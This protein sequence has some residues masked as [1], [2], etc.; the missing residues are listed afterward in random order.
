MTRSALAPVALLL[1]LFFDSAL[2]ADGIPVVDRTG[3]SAAPVVSGSTVVIPSNVAT[4]SRTATHANPVK[5]PAAV[6]TAVGELLMMLDQLQEEVAMLRGQVEQQQHQLRRMQT[7]Q[8]DRYRDLDR[9]LSLL[10]QKVLAAPPTSELLL[11]ASLPAASVETIPAVAA[12][13][14]AVAT[15]TVSDAQAFK[16]SFAL[17]RQG[18]FDAAIQAFEGFLIQYPDSS[19]TANV[20]YWTGEVHRAQ[21]NPDLH[22]AS[23]AYQQVVERYPDHAK[24]AD[25]YYKM[26]LSYQGLGQADKAKASMNK[27]IEL[28]PD[29]AP[30]MLARDFLKQ[31]R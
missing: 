11:P 14:T 17:V 8:R 13:A 26:G 25:A 1:G 9:R 5:P 4:S 6:N 18:K 31:H 28:F 20:L 15:P 24:A 7:D 12:S 10:N 16:A 27:V 3:Q 19:L 23:L 30:A 2:A 29:Q 21:S 22:K